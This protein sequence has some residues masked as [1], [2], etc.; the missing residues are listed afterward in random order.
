[1]VPAIVAGGIAAANLLGNVIQSNN[2]AARRDEM[3]NYLRGQKSETD[4]SYEGR[5]S[6]IADYYK[7]RGGLGTA[8]DV[9][10]YRT[11]IQ[12]YSPEDFVYSPDKKFDD[13]YTKTRDD[14]LNPYMQQIIGDTASQVQH[15]AAG[16]GVGRGSGAAA[17]IAK[18]VAEK[19]NELFREAQQEFK[20]DRNFE[21]NKYND[22]IAQKQRE[23][24]TKRSAMESKINLTGNLA[25][26]YYNVMD[27]QQSTV[28]RHCRTR[29][30]PELLIQARWLVC[31]DRRTLCQEFIRETILARCSR[32]RSR[33]RSPDTRPPRTGIT[34][35]SETASTP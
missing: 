13:S 15:T 7:N 32:V 20:D 26:D 30:Q 12:G 34:H 6:E 23:L 8:Q 19:E 33:M 31:T 21:Y 35:V 29:R 2:D 9:T 3:R 10:D 22:Y 1:M 27:A 24:D 25:N 14:F 18:S 17:A 4:T 28:S 16:A 5:L 11:A